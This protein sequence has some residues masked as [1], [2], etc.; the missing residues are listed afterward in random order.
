VS[1]VDEDP[2]VATTV[3]TPA[4][5]MKT[6]P[7][8]IFNLIPEGKCKDLSYINYIFLIDVYEAFQYSLKYVDSDDSA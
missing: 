2:G 4:L 1:E 5:S 8:G 6:N 7:V 3:A